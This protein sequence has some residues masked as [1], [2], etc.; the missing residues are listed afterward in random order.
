[1]STWADVAM[2]IADAFIVKPGGLVVLRDRCGRSEVVEAVVVAFERRGIT[3]I[4]DPASDNVL[5]AVLSDTEPE[6]LATWGRHRGAVLELADA[7]VTL[8]A[9]PIPIERASTDALTAL[10]AGREFMEEV[11]ARRSLP[12]LAVA[13]ATPRLATELGQTMAELDQAVRAALAPSVEVTRD[14]IATQISRATGEPLTLQT[15]G[16]SFVMKRGNRPWLHDDG[17]ISAEDTASGAVTSNLPCGSIYTTV[18][19]D[20]ATGTVRIPK[21]A[22]GRD[23]V[24][25]FSSGVVTSAEGPGAETVMPW[26]A[27]FGPDAGRISHV[28]I[29]LNPACSGGTG[30]TI[31]DEHRAGAV[32]LAFGENRYM[33]GTNAS[34]L[35][36]DI[37]LSAAS[38]LAGQATLVRNDQLIT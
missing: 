29:G 37:V 35:N 8:G 27:E 24:L 1:M 5:D 28:G 17:H 36:H 30:W 23:V 31:I 32:F 33:G 11:E 15:Q 14:L 18:L 20:S 3:T 4:I 13:V 9:G 38:L 19:E 10:R 7:V 21:I 16:C 6:L 22:D 25:T 26:L 34:A 2:R 12:F